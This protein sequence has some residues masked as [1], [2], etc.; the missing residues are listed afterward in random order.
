MTS[1]LTTVEVAALLKVSPRT[2]ADWRYKGLNLPF[3][4]P[5]GVV[6]YDPAD[7]QRFVDLNTVKPR[8]VAS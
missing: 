8:R 4:K 2:L 5:G 6:R 7:V 3:T 1:L